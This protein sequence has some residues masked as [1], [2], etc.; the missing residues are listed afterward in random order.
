MNSQ[1]DLFADTLAGPSDAD[2]TKEPMP[3]CSRSGLDSLHHHSQITD[4]D[5]FGDEF[6]RKYPF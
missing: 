2:H 3:G 5:G 4:V 6:G 1:D